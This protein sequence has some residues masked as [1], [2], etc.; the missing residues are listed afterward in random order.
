MFRKFRAVTAVSSVTSAPA[1]IGSIRIFHTCAITKT[2][3]K[4]R[5]ADMAFRV[6]DDKLI[7]EVDKFLVIYNNILRDFRNSTAKENVWRYG[8]ATYVMV[9]IIR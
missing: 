6:F 3:V 7:N 5:V 4:S 2:Q 8:A 1:Q 9:S